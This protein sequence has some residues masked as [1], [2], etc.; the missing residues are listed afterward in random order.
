M[1]EPSRTAILA[2]AI[3]AFGERGYHGTSMREVA[4]AA[5]IEK[6]VI[7]YWFA[8]KQALWEGA[9][10]DAALALVAR[11]QGPWRPA[12]GAAP[13]PAPWIQG[14]IDTVLRWGQERPEAARLLARSLVE[15]EPLQNTGAH[16]FAPFAAELHQIEAG[17]PPLL[18]A[19]IGG[20][21][22]ELL[23]RTLQDEAVPPDAGAQAVSL[24]L[25]GGA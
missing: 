25:G 23:V 16:H 12:P 22:K 7:Y 9:V 10:D 13:V 15:P 11:L 3:K 20:L 14:Y 17:G 4:V 2:E 6:S 5:G 8:S 18:G 21:V 24:L 19:A 1:S